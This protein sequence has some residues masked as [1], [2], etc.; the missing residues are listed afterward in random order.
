MC[1]P[2][3]LTYFFFS[4]WLTIGE[5]F[6]GTVLFGLDLLTVHTGYCH[7]PWLKIQESRFLFVWQFTFFTHFAPVS[8]SI[9][10]H[11]RFEE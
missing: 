5:K 11:K 6:L 9:N 4:K 8:V 10:I 2:N 7:L 1:H 3:N